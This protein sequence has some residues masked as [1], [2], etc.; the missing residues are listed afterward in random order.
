MPRLSCILEVSGVNRLKHFH[1][2]T[3]LYGG[4]SS[5]TCQSETN[6][7]SKRYCYRN[8]VKM[9]RYVQF[10]TF[11]KN[12]LH[13]Q[14]AALTVEW[15]CLYGPLSTCNCYVDISHWKHFNCGCLT[16]CNIKTTKHSHRYVTK[17]L[18]Y[19]TAVCCGWVCRVFRI[20][21]ILTNCWVSVH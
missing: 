20:I 12:P 13:C 19:I 2:R 7:D 10:C 14:I 9:W 3:G 17:T 6:K 1:W 4:L 15:Q 11:F 5:V 8:F 21:Y 16:F 18:L